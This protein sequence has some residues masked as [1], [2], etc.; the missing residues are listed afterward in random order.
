MVGCLALMAKVFI[1]KL[2]NR[3]C[4]R[5][6]ALSAWTITPQARG[7]EDMKKIDTDL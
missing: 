3:G 5:M 2:V 7:E 6:R 1:L 4:D